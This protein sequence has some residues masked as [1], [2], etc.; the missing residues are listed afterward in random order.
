MTVRLLADRRA[1]PLLLFL[2]VWLSTG[3][4]GSWEL[5]PNN[6]TRLFAAISLAEQ[7]DATIDEFAPLTI[8]KAQFDGHVYL[9]KAPGMT[10]L[11][12]P[13]VAAAYAA[14]GQGARVLTKEIGNLAFA[15][16]L[17]LRLRL[18]AWLVTG[19]ITALAT[20]ALWSFARALTGDEDAALFAA[21]AYAIATPVWGWSTTLFGHAPV[22]GLWMI[23]IWAI[24]RGTQARASRRLALVAGAALGW[25]VAI[26]YQ[27]V[28]GG[29]VIALWALARLWRR[30][31]AV[32]AAA[33]AIAGGAT[34]LAA[35][36]GYNLL[37]FGVMF[38][39]GYSGVVGFEGMQQG[40]FGLTYPKPLVLIAL[41]FGVRRGLIWVAP[42]LLRSGFGLA[43]LWRRE[44][45]LAAM[46]IVLALTVLFVNSAYVY[47]DGGY[48][49]GPRHSVPA[50][51]PLVIALAVMWTTLRT[52]TGKAAALALLALSAAVNLVITATDMFAPD[53]APFPL[54]DPILKVDFAQGMFRDLP[55]EFWGWSHWSGLALYG[56]VAGAL[57]AALLAAHRTRQRAHANIYR[58]DGAAQHPAKA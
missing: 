28:L 20:V 26:E 5:N 27:A 58:T 53:D 14:T 49:T 30:P 40:F 1:V 3:W 22:A 52:R 46:L 37:A 54:W 2:L 33:S 17:R 34:A 6:S 18:A 13:V 24:W 43:T 15:R 9:D 29:A 11:A 8:D 36:I 10:L 31:G 45:A 7:G 55:G 48:S 19:L 51:T 16:Y 32:A 50:I 56:L 42:V 41:L 21:L 23:A 35:L 57:L 38:R 47:W 4:F 12:T 25:A 39:L 44:R